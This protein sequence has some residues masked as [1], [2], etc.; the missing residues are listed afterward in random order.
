MAAF[1]TDTSV[2]PNIM[3]QLDATTDIRYT[4]SGKLTTNPIEAGRNVSDHYIQNQDTVTFSGVLTRV[5]SKGRSSLHI[6]SPS[7]Y[8]GSLQFLKNNAVPFTLTLFQE[9]TLGGFGDSKNVIK[10]LTNCIFEELNI[11]KQAGAGSSDLLV[12]FKA[13]QASF[14]DQATVTL[15]P[16]PDPAFANDASI[17]ENASGTTQALSDNKLIDISIPLI[18]GP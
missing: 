1:I 14:A 8:I 7:N 12:D 16:T 3:Y 9:P 15:Q 5:K 4:T 10:P 2:T 11:R 6:K 17:Q 18:R 13:V